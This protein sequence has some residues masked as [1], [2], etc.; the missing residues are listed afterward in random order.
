[1]AF[2]SF[3]YFCVISA[4]SMTVMT[5]I[6]NVICPLPAITMGMTSVF[7]RCDS[8]GAHLIQT[9]LGKNGGKKDCEDKKDWSVH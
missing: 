7:A 5:A 2:S 9:F 6:K 8:F 3:C 4:T 1:M